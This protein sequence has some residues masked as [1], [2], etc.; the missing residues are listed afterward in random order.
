L[1]D[2]IEQ[3]FEALGLQALEPKVE[4][5]TRSIQ[6]LDP[7]ADIVEKNEKHQVEYGGF[8]IQIN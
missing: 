4:I 6:H 7:V 2:D 3:C 8:D 1:I 5:L